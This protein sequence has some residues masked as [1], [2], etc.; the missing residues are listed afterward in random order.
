MVNEDLYDIYPGYTFLLTDIAA[1][2]FI[3][4]YSYAKASK[5]ESLMI[6]DSYEADILGAQNAGIDA[7][8]FNEQN[9]AIEHPVFQVKHLLE[10][11]N[12]L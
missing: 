6:G 11:K 1:I 5:T 3:W 2:P 9:S 10:L 8:F 12:I 7:V 4:G